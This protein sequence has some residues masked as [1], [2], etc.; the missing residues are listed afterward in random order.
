[1]APPPTSLI[2][3]FPDEIL[4]KIFEHLLASYGLAETTRATS[5]CH[6]WREIAIA[7]T[8]LWLDI[9]V[10][11]KSARDYN[12]LSA[13][14]QRS[15]K[16]PISLHLL[17]PGTRQLQS[18]LGV[19]RKHLARCESLHIRGDWA[20]FAVMAVTLGQ[21]DF[22]LLHR[23]SLVDTRAVPCQRIFPE[24]PFPLTFPLPN[25]HALRECELHGCSLGNTL[26]PN[27]HSM[28]I[29]LRSLDL[30]LNET[31]LNPQVFLI[32]TSLCI[33]GIC[34]PPMVDLLVD[35]PALTQA[36][37]VATTHLQSL[38]LKS[39]RATPV[40]DQWG[41][42]ID[43]IEEDC[44]P[45]FRALDTSSLHRLS[46]D[47]W[48]HGRILDDFI[49]VLLAARAPKFPNVTDLFLRGIDF[50]NNRTILNV[51]L[52]A[53]LPVLERLRIY[54]APD[55]ANEVMDVLSF[56]PVLCPGVCEVIT[57]TAVLLRDDG[58]PFRRYMLAYPPN[59][60]TNYSWE[61]NQSAFRYGGD[62]SE[63]EDSDGTVVLWS[64]SDDSEFSDDEG[65]QYE[66]D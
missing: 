40:R 15:Q 50:G 43:R 10:T 52:L 48:H 61:L 32:P 16:R 64:D 45:F 66:E 22:P 46:I 11:A 24:P 23:L 1:M 27:L 39:L 37:P 9:R 21:E 54:E 62:L 6:R 47:R 38:V 55:W 12:T 14:L 29:K 60:Q 41:V 8:N 53:A 18:I 26:L 28:H 30:T 20:L 49:L 44:G 2:N 35:R 63:D 58:L 31:T 19:M 7:D 5:T 25:G 36:E 42:I 4:A 13:V 17:S 59:G 34:V 3:R 56:Y 65:E 57:E 51:A 33:E